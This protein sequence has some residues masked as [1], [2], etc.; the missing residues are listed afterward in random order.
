MRQWSCRN[1]AGKEPARL[2]A[3]ETR[4]SSIA[5]RGGKRGVAPTFEANNHA[6]CSHLRYPA[7][8]ISLYF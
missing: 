2:Q 4:L 8:K 7:D 3:A 5:K 1:M 6:L